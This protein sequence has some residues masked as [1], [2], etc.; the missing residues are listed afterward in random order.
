V[1]LESR[2]SPSGRVQRTRG[3][4]MFG[5]WGGSFFA[6]LDGSVGPRHDRSRSRRRRRSTWVAA[7]PMSR[8]AITHRHNRG[9]RC[10]PAESQAVRVGRAAAD[11]PGVERARTSRVSGRAAVRRAPRGGWPKHTRTAMTWSSAATWPRRTPAGAHPASQERH[12]LDGRVA[13][14]GAIR[15]DDDPAAATNAPQSAA[16]TVIT[17]PRPRSL[18]SATCTCPPTCRTCTQAFNS[19][20]W[21]EVNQPA[22]RAGPAHGHLQCRP[23]PF[24]CTARFAAGCASWTS[25]STRP[26]T[27]WSPTSS[28]ARLP[29]SASYWPA[30]FR[31]TPLAAPPAARG[32]AA[33]H[34]GRATSGAP[35]TR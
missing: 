4:V 15:R 32:W 7:R 6:E 18:E 23:R 8:R 22:E 9:G 3:V 35:R 21:L 14:L 10:P 30:T 16:V 12:P 27:R 24:G 28:A 29:A 31:C 5:S 33:R 11:E 13:Q 17:G 2:G 1:R 26:A 20:L 25:Y 19:S 34:P